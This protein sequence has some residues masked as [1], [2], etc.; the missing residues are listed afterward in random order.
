MKINL[1]KELLERQ[2][3]DT[4]E[5][6]SLDFVSAPVFP[7]SNKELQIRDG[8]TKRDSEQN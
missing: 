8:Y 4:T 6:D 2:A 7:I 5:S 3:I 1:P